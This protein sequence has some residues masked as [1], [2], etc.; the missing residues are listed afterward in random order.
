MREFVRINIPPLDRAW[1]KLHNCIQDGYVFQVKR[2]WTTRHGNGMAELIGSNGWEIPW[3]NKV[4]DKW[5]EPMTLA[6]YYA[7]RYPI[8]R[9]QRFV[10][11]KTQ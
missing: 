2:R 6:E 10:T 11:R 9:L 8:P 7:Y 4:M 5:L 1:F 3:R